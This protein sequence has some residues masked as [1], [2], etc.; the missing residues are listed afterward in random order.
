MKTAAAYPNFKIT[1]MG[2][3]GMYSV[4]AAHDMPTN[5]TKLQIF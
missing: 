4:F 5:L 3:F 2:M 1:F